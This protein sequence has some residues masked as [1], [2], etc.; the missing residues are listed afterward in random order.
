M[1]KIYKTTQNISNNIN[2]IIYIYNVFK[3]NLLFFVWLYYKIK[4]II[5]LNNFLKNIKIAKNN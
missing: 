1:I 4:K 2:F 3:F 5:K